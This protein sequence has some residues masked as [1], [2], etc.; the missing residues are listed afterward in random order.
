MCRSIISLSKIAYQMWGN[1]PCSNRNSSGSGWGVVG[2]RKG[3]RRVGRNSKKR[4]IGTKGG[5]YVK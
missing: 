2:D 5:V 3:R 4:G 1:N